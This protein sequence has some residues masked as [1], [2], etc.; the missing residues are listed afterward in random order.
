MDRK[1]KGYTILEI[2]VVI[3][4]MIILSYI[5]VKEFLV[6]VAKI[7]LNSAVDQLLGDLNWIKTK[8]MISEKPWGFCIE[9]ENSY[10]LFKDN[11]SDGNC[12]ENEI[13]R[14][15][16]LSNQYP[17]VKIHASTYMCENNHFLIYNRSGRV[18]SLWGNII[19]INQ[20]NEIKTITI[21][22]FGINVS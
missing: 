6:Y 16:N 8:S 22:E 15:I 14:R 4:L 19:L 13:E 1:I 7:R 20:Y 3:S 11:D 18:Y 12:D 10:V 2:L 21:S 17:G 5:G 9:N